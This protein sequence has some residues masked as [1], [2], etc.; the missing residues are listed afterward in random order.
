MSLS[1]GITGDDSLAHVVV[2]RL[3][4][5]P[6]DERLPNGVISFD[7]EADHNFSLRSADGRTSFEWGS[8]HHPD[9]T[10]YT[11]AVTL[12]RILDD[13][14]SGVEAF[15][16]GRLRVRGNLALA[17]SLNRTWGNGSRPS[18]FPTARTARA[19]RYDTLYLEA[20]TGETMVLLHGLGATN[21]SMLPTMHEFAPDY[22]VVVPDLPGFGGSAKPFRPLHAQFFARWLNDFMIATGIDKAHLVGNSM[23]GRVA[24]EMGLS[25]PERVQSLVLLAPSPA[26]IKN[27]QFVQLVRVLRPE[28]ALLPTPVTRGLVMRLLRSLFARPERIADAWHEAAADEFLRV[29]SSPLGR[30]CFFSAARQIY[31]EEP[32]GDDGFWDRLPSLQARSL[33]VWGDRDRVVP[34]SFKRHVDRVLPS[35]SSVVMNDCGHV[36]QYELPGRTHRSIREFIRQ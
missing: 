6:S 9:A 31:L 1:A 20:G 29:F 11:D 34:A 15:L 32:Y 5:M 19:G 4:T 33:F 21:A 10:V 2:D 27:R 23:G 17:L 14:L 3:R 8:T 30:I 26:F 18:H 12:R 24:I 16:D 13:R 35:A 22:R 36:P 28:L 7:I 25:F